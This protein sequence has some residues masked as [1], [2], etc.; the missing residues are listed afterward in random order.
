MAFLAWQAART[1][2]VMNLIQ[3]WI[4]ADPG[5]STEEVVEPPPEGFENIHNRERPLAIENP[6]TGER[7]E[8]RSDEF[9]AYRRNGWKV[10]LKPDDHLEMMHMQAWYFKVRHFPRLNVALHT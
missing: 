7:R 5:D 3:H 8:V 6:Q 4:N 1:P 2:G 9:H 10:V